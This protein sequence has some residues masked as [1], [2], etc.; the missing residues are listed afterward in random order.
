MSDTIKDAYLYYSKKKYPDV[1][2]ILEPQVFRFRGNFDFFYLLG[3]SC[4]HQG[5]YGGGFSYLKRALDIKE[6]DIN[7]LLGLAF[8]YLKRGETSSALRIWLD[9]IDMDPSNQFAKRGLNFLKKNENPDELSTFASADKLNKFLPQEKFKKEKKLSL[10]FILIPLII[11][12]ALIIIF[13]PK[14]KNKAIELFSSE[15]EK[16]PGVSGI[17]LDERKDFLILNGEYTYILTED[18]V[19]KDFEKIQDYL[20]NFKDNLAQKEINKLLQS[21][22]SEYVKNRARILEKYIQTPDLPSFKNNFDYK[23][24]AANPLL[25]KNCYVLWK[26]KATNLVQ[27]TKSIDFDFLVGYHEEKILEG[28][29]PV[30]FNFTIKVVPDQPIELFAKINLDNTGNITLTGVAIRLL[31]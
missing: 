30:S 6:N 19:E 13:F 24:V 16:R 14:I 25:Y 21:N 8:I 3:M 28:V 12:L 26:G 17:S 5:D 22:A 31:P 15:K 2:R 10:I 1:I 11:I 29:L 18:E 9:I 4:L 27:S 20:Y 23:T 7:A